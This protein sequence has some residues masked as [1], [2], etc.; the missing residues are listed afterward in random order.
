M[1]Q[2]HTQ[3]E[4]Q[5]VALTALLRRLASGSGRLKH[6]E[7][8]SFRLC[9]RWCKIRHCVVP[10]WKKARLQHMR[11][12]EKTNLSLSFLLSACV[13][14]VPLPPCIWTNSPN[15]LHCYIVLCVFCL[16][17]NIHLAWLCCFATNGALQHRAIYL[18]STAVASIAAT[19]IYWSPHV[20]GWNDDNLCIPRIGNAHPHFWS[21]TYIGRSKIG[22]NVVECSKTHIAIKELVITECIGHIWNQRL[23]T[24]R[25]IQGNA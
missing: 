22:A 14:V 12:E 15:F 1:L 18:S 6:L 7:Q 2:F 23:F 21:G 19:V 24:N 9:A 10:W 13:K 16:T 3:S 11:T 25:A 4:V 17:L 8:P 20:Q 5:T